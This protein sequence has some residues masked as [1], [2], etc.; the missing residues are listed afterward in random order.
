MLKI[1][2]VLKNSIARELGIKKGDEILAFDGFLCEDVLDYLY[3][4]SLSFF[5]VTVKSGSEEIEFEIEKDEDESL[6]VEFES[7]NLEIKNCRNK[8]VFCFVDQMPKGMRP[9]LY[10][11]DDDYRQSFLRGN[12]VTLT[13]VSDSEIDRIIRLNLSPLYVSVHATDG[14]VR[15][16]LLGNRFAGDVLDKLK[17][18]TENGIKVHTQI[19]LVPSLNDGAVLDKTCHDLVALGKNVLSIAV[20]PCGITRFREGLYNIE[21]VDSGY[22]T[23]VISQIG[24]LNALLKTNIITP[25]DEF[26]F[27]AKLPLPSEDFYNGYPQIENGVGVTAKFLSE[28][29]SAVKTS[30]NGKNY[31]VVSGTSA[32]SFILEQVEFVKGY[33][34]GLNATVLSV[35]NEFFG[36]TVNCTGL[37][38]GKDILNAVLKLDLSKYDGIILPDVCLKR[39]ES[40]FLDGFTLKDLSIKT[41]LEV[42]V[43][44]GSGESF[45]NA[46]SGRKIK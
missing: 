11:K 25:A 31:I 12:F 22:A 35:E 15:K 30:Q 38:V 36:K 9:S 5:T 14:E 27:K 19:V 6:G 32:S 39:E 28:L 2:K 37:L 4:D 46:L 8:C 13:N 41:G 24:S 45:F 23:C 29:K 16:K 40:V 20:V 7:D 42:T 3:Y 21:D 17:K 34:S 18:L 1:S 44:D 33:V 43:T 26:Y 10:L